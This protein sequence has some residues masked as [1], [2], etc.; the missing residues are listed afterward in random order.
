MLQSH[1]L[2]WHYLW[3][4]PHVLQ[5]VLAIFLWRRGL[6][7]LFPVFFAY[8]I[9]EAVEEFTLY[10]MDIIP[11]V[12]VRA[13]WIALCASLVIEGAFMFGV[14][15]ELLLHLLRSR[16]AIAKVGT[17]LFSVAGATLLL[18]A[19]AAAAYAPRDQPQYI[20]TYR[21]HIL[22]QSLYIVEGG[23]ALFLFLFVGHHKLTWDRKD[24]G[25]ALGFG[26]LFCEHMA[27]YSVMAT[28]A[29]PY[30]RYPLLDLLNMATYH[31]CVLIWFYYLAFP[32]KKSAT[33]AVPLPEN[34]LDIW[35][36]ELE[37]L[38]QQ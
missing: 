13:W 36:R 27:T 17:R 8:T 25:I 3:L 24:F 38:L 18:L 34:N 2:L 12:S 30:S 21:A 35:N 26:I 22:L 32:Q 31:V 28:G 23:L 1:S 11:S 15:R 20:W 4:G 9:F 10:G 16:L 33:S 37:R 5:L 14:L 29:L 6:H 19:I 7:K